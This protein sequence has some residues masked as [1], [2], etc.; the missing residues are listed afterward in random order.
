M[1][2]IAS[3]AILGQMTQMTKDEMQLG[4]RAKHERGKCVLVSVNV[5]G[6]GTRRSKVATALGH[7]ATK[8]PAKTVAQK[9]EKPRVGYCVYEN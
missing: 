1:G 6:G 9:G 7:D 5:Y 4:R 3:S 2:W 8:R